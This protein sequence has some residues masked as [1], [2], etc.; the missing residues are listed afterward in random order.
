MAMLSV[1]N[2][3]FTGIVDLIHYHLLSKKFELKGTLK[4]EFTGRKKVEE[5]NFQEATPVGR[6]SPQQ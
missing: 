4:A 3:K 5:C 6:S 2:N 1:V